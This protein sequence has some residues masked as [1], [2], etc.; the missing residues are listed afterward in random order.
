MLSG[1]LGRQQLPSDQLKLQAAYIHRSTK[2]TIPAKLLQ[3]SVPAAAWYCWLGQASCLLH[4]KQVTA[5]IVSRR[6]DMPG[7]WQAPLVPQAQQCC[8]TMAG[9]SRGCAAA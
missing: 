7:D 4:G 6:H 8:L 1:G 2:T 9:C 3:Y 5:T